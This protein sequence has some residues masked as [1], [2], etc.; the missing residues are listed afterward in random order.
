MLIFYPCETS[1][2]SKTSKTFDAFSYFLT[3]QYFFTVGGLW[4]AYDFS[5]LKEDKTVALYQVKALLS[6]RKHRCYT[7]S[8]S[9]ESAAEKLVKHKKECGNPSAQCFLVSS[10]AITDW[11]NAD[12]PFNKEITLYKYNGS[13]VSI[14]DCPNY[15]QREIKA[16]VKT[17][18]TDIGDEEIENIY[19]KLCVFLDKS[20]ATMHSQGS[21]DRVYCI[22][23]CVFIELMDSAIISQAEREEFRR[24]EYIYKYLT[25]SFNETITKYCENDCTKDPCEPECVLHRL[26]DE[27]SNLKDIRKYIEVINPDFFPW[28]D[29]LNY[30]SRASQNDIKSHI[31][32][33]FHCSQNANAIRV[34]YNGITFQSNLSNAKNKLVLPTLLSIGANVNRS[35]ETLLH[36]IRNNLS[37]Q[38]SIA[39]NTLLAAMDTD[40]MIGLQNDCI[41]SRWAVSEDQSINNPYADTEIVSEQAFLKEL[42]NEHD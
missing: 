42:R 33:A 13:I 34:H 19:G 9:K 7:S 17:K 3:G 23:L 22:P 15:I 27:F 20:I 18:R 8:S 41:T 37:V 40:I 5:I 2:I 24:N 28:S 36:N 1:E 6:Q 29:H 32:H 10:V 31:V 12:N 30:I 11:D 25:E 39:G 16:F 26:E 4:S 14:L 21:H 35:L 38:P